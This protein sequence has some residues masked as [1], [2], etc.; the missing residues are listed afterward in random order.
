MNLRL[1][2]LLGLA[3]IATPA[4]DP[5]QSVAMLLGDWVGEGGGAP[6]QGGGDCSFSYDL[7]RKI[8]VRRNASDFPASNEQP[9]VHHRDLMIL[10]PGPPMRA[11]YFDNEGHFIRYRV[12]A[13]GKE[14]R[15]GS[16]EPGTRYR[17]RY[18]KLSADRMSLTFEI[19][20]SGRPE[21]FKMY[22]NGS[23]KRK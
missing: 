7:D 13:D 8:I 21:D 20:G 10:H 16:D 1:A 17:L 4:A 9:A 15:F 11:D 23:L 2:L 19:S 3:A 12:T 14:V 22:V 18:A 6:G 5:W